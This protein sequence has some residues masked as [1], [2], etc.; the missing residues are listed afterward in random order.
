MPRC[1]ITGASGFV[2]LNLAESLVEKGWDVR[3]LVR[4]TS[5]IERLTSLGVR[6]VEGSLA[7]Q[8]S[9][10]KAVADMDVVYHLAGR[11]QALR[12]Q[13]FD[14]DNV[15]GTR[16]VAGA[17]A[18]QPKPPV[19]VFVS[20]IAA[21][22]PATD[23]P[24]SET[25]VSRPVSNYGRSKLA[26]E[27]AAASFAARV[28]LSI[29][30]SPI[31]FGP[32]D[33][34]SLKIFLEV[35]RLHL[36]AVPGFRGFPVSVI[37]VADLCNALQLV[38]EKGTR[39]SPTVGPSLKCPSLDNKVDTAAGTYYVA[40]QR[41]IDY[42]ELGRLAAVAM[43]TRVLILPVP[44]FA[45]WIAGG[46][47]ECVGHFVRRPCYLNFDKMREATAAGWVCSDEKIR[48][49]LGYQPAA[50]LEQQFATTVQWYREQGW[51]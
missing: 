46:I 50:T 37:H 30:R 15:E 23:P 17:C 33:H 9:L 6:L 2:G 42:G 41:P 11:L 1:L 7:D 48:S 36:H 16:H 21:G 45:F 35:K 34:A 13:D 18:E 12:R 19:L 25:D 26:A 28:P 8:A 43:E 3:C 51:I 27:G 49:E 38:A 44:K 5:K 31:I 22:G 32:A 20:S 40:S 47:C 10:V 29:V 24:L 4:P 39:V 14:R